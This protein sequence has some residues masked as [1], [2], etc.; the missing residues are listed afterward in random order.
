MKFAGG[1]TKEFAV[2]RVSKTGNAERKKMNRHN[3]RAGI[4]VAAFQCVT[5]L[6]LRQNLCAFFE[7]SPPGK[8]WYNCDRSSL[9]QPYINL[10]SYLKMFTNAFSL[11]SV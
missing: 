6:A 8:L 5:Y 3:I 11:H 2:T 1:L 7:A 9:I 10:F 4:K